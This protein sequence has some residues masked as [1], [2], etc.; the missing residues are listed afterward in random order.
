MAEGREFSINFKSLEQLIQTVTG[1]NNFW[2]QNAFVTCSWRFLITN[3]LEHLEF[4]LEKIIW[5]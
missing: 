2:L 1:Q 3:D 5:I 4:K